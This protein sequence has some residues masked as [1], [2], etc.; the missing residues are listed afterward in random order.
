MQ[1]SVILAHPT[2]TSFNHAV[3][4]AAIAELKQNGHQVLFHDLYAEEFDP[5]LPAV[6][7]LKEPPLPKRSRYIA[8]KYPA[9]MASS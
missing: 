7:L 4:Q 6:K 3:A 8:R 5:I 9:Q 1:V 2:S